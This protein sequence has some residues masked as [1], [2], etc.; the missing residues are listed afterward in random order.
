MMCDILKV[1]RSGYYKWLAQHNDPQMSEED[2][3]CERIFLL[4]QKHK[5]I[6]GYRRITQALNREG[7]KQYNVKR[8]RRL[9]QLMGLQSVIRRPRKKHLPTTPEAIQEN[10]LN[11]SFEAKDSNEKWLTDITEFVYGG[12]NKAFLSAIL[13]VGDNRIVAWILGHRNNN[14]LVFRTF[15][16]AFTENAEATPL[17]HSDRGFQYTSIA[18]RK[19]LVDTKCTQ[20]MSR[21]GNC[22]DNAPMES[23]WGALKSEMYYLNR[24]ETYTQL[25]QAV[26]EYMVFYNHERYQKK[27]QGLTPMEARYKAL[28]A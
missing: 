16:C 5:G 2:L 25:E 13:D 21:K 1:S 6:Y 8:I 14:E 24:F 18:F 17:V 15:K 20:S 4:H 23:F 11:R 7:S 19:L 12:Q 26:R 9:M 22:W 3:L 10:R 27:L 28:A